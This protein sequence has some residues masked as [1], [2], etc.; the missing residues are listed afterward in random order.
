MDKVNIVKKRFRMAIVVPVFNVDK[1]LKHCLEAFVNQTCTEFDVF[2]IDDGSTDNSSNILEGYA[3][4]VKWLKVIHK[5][6]AGVSSA[7]N[8]ALTLIENCHMYTHVAFIDADDWVSH[9]YVERVN[10][11]IND[12]I[13]CFICGSVKFDRRGIKQSKLSNVTPRMVRGVKFFDFYWE[14]DLNKKSLSATYYL[15]NKVFNLKKIK[16]I[17]FDERIR[18]GED[19]DWM[20]KCFRV[21]KSALVS[22][23]VLHYYRLRASSA[24]HTCWSKNIAENLDMYMR[25][26]C[27]SRSVT[28]LITDGFVRSFI[29]MWWEN[30]Q[31]VYQ[32]E[33]DVERAKRLREIIELVYLNGDYRLLHLKMKKRIWLYRCGDAFLKWYFRIFHKKTKLKLRGRDSAYFFD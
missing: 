4:K 21:V 13:D 22:E 18:C 3:K 25:Y 28:E 27:E 23:E 5:E 15:G 2:A 14:G 1:Y 32:S 20:F 17:R 10:S 9:N 19:Q 24:S 6:N 33:F 16:G 7:R 8:F 26:Y 11:L 12:S 29:N 30:V 31:Y